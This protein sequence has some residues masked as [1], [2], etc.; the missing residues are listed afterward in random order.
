MH[1]LDLFLYHLWGLLTIV[2][3]GSDVPCNDTV[4]CLDGTTCCK[5]AQGDWACCPLPQAVCCEDFIHCCPQ[6][7][8]CNLAAQTC[9]DPLGSVP[10]L[11]KEP[12]RPIKGQKVPET[13]GSDVPCNDTVACLDGTTCC[14]T[15]QGDWACC[16]IPKVTLS[17][18]HPLIFLGTPL[19]MHL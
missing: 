5:T 6:G 8:K 12:T 1:L 17:L 3:L 15:A 19:Q 7:K 11:K 10:W 2:C 16:P 13:K 4:A 14:K 9:D 18:S